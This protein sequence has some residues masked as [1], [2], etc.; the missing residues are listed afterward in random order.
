MR[1]F[2]TD[3]F[4]TSAADFEFEIRVE[5]TRVFRAFTETE[6]LRWLVALRGTAQYNQVRENVRN[7]LKLTPQAVCVVVVGCFGFFLFV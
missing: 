3:V 2:E 4:E 7:T 6:Y 1:I 5:G